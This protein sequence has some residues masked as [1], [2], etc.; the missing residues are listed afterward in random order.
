MS[1]ARSSW[2]TAATGQFESSRSSAAKAREEEKAE[3]LRLHLVGGFQDDLRL[4][5]KDRDRTGD[6]DDLAVERLDV[7]K[8]RAVTGEDHR[9]EGVVG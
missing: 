8:F 6:I 2:P 9:G 1:P 4:A 7:W 5:A 3:L